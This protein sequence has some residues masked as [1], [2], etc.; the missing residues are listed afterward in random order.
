MAQTAPAG[1][2]LGV[3]ASASFTPVA[4]AY[5]AGDVIGA[6]KELQWMFTES[7]LKVPPGALLR[8]MTAFTKIDRTGVISG[9][10]SYTLQVYNVTQP[11]AQAD[12]DAWTLASADLSAYCGSIAL[13]TPADLGAALFV[14]TAVETDVPLLST[15]SSVYGRLVGVGGATLTTESIQISLCGIIV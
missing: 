6:S 3:V 12:N 8:V 5:T 15:S 13:G 1:I 9:E 4:A 11:S 14:R 10:T 7:G 2:G